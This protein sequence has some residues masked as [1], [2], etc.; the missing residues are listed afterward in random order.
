MGSLGDKFKKL[1]GDQTRQLLQ[2]FQNAQSS[3]TKNGY[4]YGK[5]NEDG[6]ATLAD[7]TVVQTVVK[8]RPGQ[9][10]P[11]FNLG[12]GQ[13]L[14]DQPEAKFFTVD[15]GIRKAWGIYSLRG[16]QYQ[17][18]TD[19]FGDPIY[20]VPYNYYLIDLISGKSFF[21]FDSK[22]LPYVLGQKNFDFTIRPSAQF[23]ESGKNLC[24][25]LNYMSYSQGSVVTETAQNSDVIWT[26]SLTDCGGFFDACYFTSVDVIVSRADFY[27]TVGS[28][29]QTGIVFR[30]LNIADD[31]LSWEEEVLFDSKIAESS[32]TPEG[33]YTPPTYQINPE[34]IYNVPTNY[35]NICDCGNP[36]PCFYQDAPTSSSTLARSLITYPTVG[37]ILLPQYSSFAF[38]ILNEN[39]EITF[40]YLSGANFPVPSISTTVTRSTP[41]DGTCGPTTAT[42]TDITTTFGS[43]NAL[44]TITPSESDPLMYI[45]T[46]TISNGQPSVVRSSQLASTLGG[47][48]FPISYSGLFQGGPG[49]ET[50]PQSIANSEVVGTAAL[51]F[52]SQAQENQY[53]LYR[54]PFN[55][56]SILPLDTEDR[57]ISCVLRADN[58]IEYVR[59]SQVSEIGV[60]YSA[61]PCRR[62]NQILFYR[63]SG[64]T[65][66]L[67]K[68][69]SESGQFKE[70]KSYESLYPLEEVY[71]RVQ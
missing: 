41:I 68:L 58:Q 56:S 45:A 17:V 19:V 55:I 1:A 3:K 65:Y 35:I 15:S 5:L 28:V 44:I 13:G 60:P 57:P 26:A 36:P 62:D 51:S 20:A 71:I 48:I 9:Y 61:K 37:G 34:Y 42:A 70:L 49:L 29:Y 66:T 23:D 30:N 59:L 52:F 21:L 12:N 46:T 47:I 50:L 53:Y 18:S 7:G 24:L 4:S 69:D 14:V 8:G 43:P 27:N 11:V 64:Y 31:E 38:R 40:S 10:A 39:P 25:L 63:D 6:T 16:T 2:N 33:T 67:A 22:N 32:S 54:S